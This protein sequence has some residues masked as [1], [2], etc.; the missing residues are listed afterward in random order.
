MSN[1][2]TSLGEFGPLSEL[3]SGVDVGVVRPLKSFLQ[4]LQLFGREGGTTASLLPLQGQVGLRL[5]IRAFVRAVT[6]E[7]QS[8]IHRSTTILIKKTRGARPRKTQKSIDDLKS[9]ERPAG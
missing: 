6:C 9:R 3:F 2:H 8:S 4:L 5:H 7:T 1:L